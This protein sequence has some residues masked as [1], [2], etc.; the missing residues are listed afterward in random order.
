MREPTNLNRL[1]VH[2]VLQTRMA[3]PSFEDACRACDAASANGTNFVTSFQNLASICKD[4][5]NEAVAAKAKDLL[6]IILCSAPMCSTA[7]RVK[8]VRSVAICVL[9]SGPAA[10]SLLST[11]LIK[12]SSI[13]AHKSHPR[14]LMPLSA[15]PLTVLQ[16]RWSR[17]V[18]ATQVRCKFGYAKYA[19]QRSH[20]YAAAVFS[21]SHLHP[22]PR[23]N[24]G[25]PYLFLQ[26]VCQPLSALR[27][28][29][30]PFFEIVTKG[31]C[32]IRVR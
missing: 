23:S 8:A 32:P 29:L 18:L 21:P 1:S 15:T 4:I 17:P 9:E 14:P 2:L 30:L 20:I 11:G 6:R 3:T 25:A 22:H 26:L 10:A 24:L 5:G 27:L 19:C 7:S 16:L 13:Y 12:G 28:T 31:C